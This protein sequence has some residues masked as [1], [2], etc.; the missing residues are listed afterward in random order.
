ME[1]FVRNFVRHYANVVRR[2]KAPH[3]LKL[4]SAI[5]YAEAVLEITASKLFGTRVKWLIVLLIQ[6]SK[7]VVRLQLLIVHHTAMQPAP[8]LFTLLAPQPLSGTPRSPSQQLAPL[9]AAA[10]QADDD[11]F[12]LSCSGRVVRSIQSG[13]CHIYRNRFQ[14]QLVYTTCVFQAPDNLDERDWSMQAI[15]EKAKR[16]HQSTTTA[17]PD[18]DPSENSYVFAAELLHIIR[19]ISHMSCLYVC[20]DKSWAQFMLPLVIDTVRFIVRHVIIYLHT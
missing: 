5:E 6:L 20:S 10:T 11:F 14:S 15:V 2:W 18:L 7:C 1:T 3:L 9:S 13:K 8:S 12:V 16:R 4:L 17:R 19:P